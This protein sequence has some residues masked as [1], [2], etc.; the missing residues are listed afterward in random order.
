MPDY[1]A[2]NSDLN[3]FYI[4]KQSLVTGS[5]REREEKLKVGIEEKEVLGNVLNQM[6]R[7]VQFK[8]AHEIVHLAIMFVS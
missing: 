8:L 2:F 7:L 6:I 5:D 3:T 4:D 1:A